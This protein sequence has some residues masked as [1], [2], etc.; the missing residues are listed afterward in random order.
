MLVKDVYK[1]GRA[2]DIKKVADG[3]GRNFLLPQGLAALATAGAV[4]QAEKIRAQAEVKR[5]ELNS[6]LKDL[7]T[8]I[9]AVVLNFST[10]AGE[11]GKL[12][13]SITTQDVAT[14]IQEQT[15]YEVKKQQIDMQ[16][17]RNLGEFKARVRLTMD[18]V[19]EVKV[20]VYREGEAHEDE[21]AET[22]EAEA[23]AAEGAEA[24]AS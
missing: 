19:P 22:A 3:Y 13:G 5:A 10:K 23:P 17:I 9:G 7:A 8:Q 2:G 24:P 15:R 11:T 1:L 12:Y 20:I 6:E 16:P 18:L 4:K 14:A 21:T